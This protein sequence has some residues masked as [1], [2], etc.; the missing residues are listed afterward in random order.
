[1]EQAKRKDRSA[2]CTLKRFALMWNSYT[3]GFVERIRQ[4]ML[5]DPWSLLFLFFVPPLLA[6][7][8]LIL[9]YS[10]PDAGFEQNWVHWIFGLHWGCLL[11]Y[12]AVPQWVQVVM[13]VKFPSRCTVLWPIIY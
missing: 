12:W 11:C 3:P 6:I 2:L 5:F 8:P 13:D 4:E 7:S 10:R 1:M 9:P